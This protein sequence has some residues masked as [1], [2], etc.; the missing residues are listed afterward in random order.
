MQR[1]GSLGFAAIAF[2]VALGC[3]PAPRAASPTAREGGTTA[4]VRGRTAA[5]PED[6]T[7]APPRTGARD[8]AQVAAPVARL[9]SAEIYYAWGDYAS[10]ARILGRTTPARPRASLLLG[11]SLY[12]LGRMSDAVSAFERGLELA[13]DN[14]DLINGHAFALY[15]TEQPE[16]AEA[17]FRRILDTNPEREESIRGLAAVLYTSQRFAECLPIADRLLRDHPGDAEAEHHLVKSV[18]GMLTAWRQA[19]RT[20]AEMVAEAWRLE[21]A[22]SRRSALEIFRW[23]LTVDP[24]HPGAR[25][26]LGMLGPA[27][28]REVEARRALE[29]L[30]R[31]NADDTQARA[32]LARLHLD[33]GRVREASSEVD[34]LLAANPSDTRAIELRE[35]IRSRKRGDS[36]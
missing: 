26:G 16:R 33:A 17:E 34:A 21:A 29:E 24:F 20:P 14:L 9:D 32:A 8:A 5:A 23:V 4:P 28:G 18:D 22:G 10:V 12:R 6:V 27:F 7:P 19:G 2:V 35:E 13:P 30:L 36:K 3:G 15:R 25:L 31:E 1:A 11:W